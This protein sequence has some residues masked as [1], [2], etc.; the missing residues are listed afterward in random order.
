MMLGSPNEKFFHVFIFFIL[1]FYLADFYKGNKTIAFGST[2]KQGESH[3]ST[4][5]KSKKKVKK[6]AQLIRE[7]KMNVGFQM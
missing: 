5:K 6:S 1:L 7:E 3:K 2:L 4:K